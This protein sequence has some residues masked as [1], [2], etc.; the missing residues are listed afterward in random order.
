[1]NTCEICG[2]SFSTLTDLYKHKLIHN[3]SLVLHRGLKRPRNEDEEFPKPKKYREDLNESILS[4]KTDIPLPESDSDMETEKIKN[5]IVEKELPRI[6]FKR[7]R[8]EDGEYV[9]KRAALSKEVVPSKKQRKIKPK[10]KFYPMIESNKPEMAVASQAKIDPA[11]VDYKTMYENCL[12][13]LKVQQGKFKKE[14]D[15]MKRE[16][17]IDILKIKR[18]FKKI[19][20]DL[21]KQLANQK[22]HH[23]EN[24]KDVES[25]YEDNIKILK[26]KIKSKE[27]GEFKTLTEA[28][29]NCTTIEEIYKIK[30]LLKEHRIEELLDNHLD[31][32]QK[33]FISLSYGVI[34]ICQPQRNVI[35]KSQRK[36][37]EKIETSSAADAKEL[38]IGN[39]MEI[40]KLFA[41]IEESLQLAT[42]SYKKFT[43][44]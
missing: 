9:P 34:P 41:I 39:K 35:S 20:R 27:G 13:E 33:L 12:V 14:I 5:E 30:S 32:L 28:I 4:L 8:N 19:E 31:T 40:I 15:N 23:D 26:E 43:K 21:K 10:R 44:K 18:K 17:G 6:G 1:M 11:P 24:M 42:R 38:I 2:E 3:N 36:L 22:K 29:F 37:I 25:H 7:P 16:C